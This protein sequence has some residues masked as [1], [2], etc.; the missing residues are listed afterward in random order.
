L[1]I[2]TY[3]FNK[4]K[5]KTTTTTTTTTQLNPFGKSLKEKVLKSFHV[6]FHL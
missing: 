6:R 3:F 1:G 2:E 4:E 5:T